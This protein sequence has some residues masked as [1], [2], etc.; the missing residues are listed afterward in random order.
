MSE[1]ILETLLIKRDLSSF[2]SECSLFF[3]LLV[4]MWNSMERKSIKLNCVDPAGIER[5][6]STPNGVYVILCLCEL[7]WV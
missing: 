3:R 6:C 1:D 2:T 7:S 5:M 4:Y